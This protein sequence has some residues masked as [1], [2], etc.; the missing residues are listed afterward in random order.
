M[1][2]EKLTEYRIGDSVIFFQNCSSNMNTSAFILCGIEINDNSGIMAINQYGELITIN[3]S[4][5]S[6]F[7]KNMIKRNRN[8]LLETNIYNR[9]DDFMKYPH[10]YL[11]LP[12][13]EIYDRQ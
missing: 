3:N 13:E 9:Y 7:D 8:I 4:S 11:F 5:L 12:A 2:A 1:I 10:D 6:L